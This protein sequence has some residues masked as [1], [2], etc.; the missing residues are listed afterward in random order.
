MA[1][2]DVRACGNC[3]MLVVLCF[4]VRSKTCSAIDVAITSRKWRITCR[5]HRSRAHAALGQFRCD[6]LSVVGGGGGRRHTRHTRRKHGTR[7]A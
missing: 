5:S 7:A 4:I 3:L 6:Q 1:E 2:E